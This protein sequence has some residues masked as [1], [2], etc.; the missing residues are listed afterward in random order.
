MTYTLPLIFRYLS[1]ILQFVTFIFVTRRLSPTEAGIYFEI[2]GIVN[3][4]YFLAGLGLPDGLVRFVS[5]ADALDQREA[6][7]P[8]VWRATLWTAWLSLTL[9]L[10][11]Y[12]SSGYDSRLRVWAAAWWICYAAVFFGSQVLVAIGKTSWGAFFFYPATS[13][14]LFLATVPYLM[15]SRHPTI[16]VTLQV[17]FVGAFCCAAA[18][19]FSLVVALKAF[20]RSRA[21]TSLRAVFQQGFYIGIARVLQTSLYWIPVW[22]VG[23]ALGAVYA[24]EIGTASRLNAAIA[25]VMAAIRFTIRPSIVRY[26]AKGQWE[27]IARESRQV[28]TLA[29]LSTLLAFVVTLYAGASIIGLIFGHA[30]RAGWAV[31][32]VLLIGTLGE[33]IGGPVDEILKMTGRAP[34]VTI[35]LTVG[36][37][38]EAGLV[39]LL[40]HHGTIA[41]A[42]AQAITFVS[43]YAFMLWLVWKENHVYVGAAISKVQLRLLRN[44]MSARNV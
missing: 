32:A 30:Y 20:P 28:A 18:S 44:R 6:I 10:I 24:G 42:S 8:L 37:F 17:T 26:A 38:F 2:Y 19:L 21:K 1:M 33:C 15:F 31:L 12:F 5:H 7:R 4:T 3:T 41:I 27:S 16:Q 11:G 14:G 34:T 43:M 25:A 23:W 40:G 13:I 36:A 29:T 35:A 39:L 9:V 22:G